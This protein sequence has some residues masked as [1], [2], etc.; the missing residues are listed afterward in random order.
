MRTRTFW[1]QLLYRDEILK[2]KMSLKLS[3]EVPKDEQNEYATILVAELVNS[4]A[5]TEST[6]VVVAAKCGFLT[7]ERIKT[8]KLIQRVLPTQGIHEFGTNVLFR[9]LVT[10]F[11]RNP[12]Y[13]TST[14]VLI[15]VQVP[16]SVP[17]NQKTRWTKT[18]V[19]GKRDLLQQSRRFVDVKIDSHKGGT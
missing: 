10:N 18:D 1:H 16:C 3:H 7:V 11:G 5:E 4:H 13:S 14:H 12:L 6:I 8:V 19:R 17:W 9:I 15:W 2:P